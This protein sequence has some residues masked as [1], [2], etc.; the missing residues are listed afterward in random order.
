MVNRLEK[1]FAPL[2]FIQEGKL[3]CYKR[4]CLWVLAGNKVLDKYP[5]FNSAKEFL[6]GAINPFSRLLRLGIRASIALDENRVLLSRGNHIFELDLLSGERSGGYFIGE[7]L[8][9]LA[10]T[11]IEGIRG[12]DDA[13]VFGGYL[14]NMDKEPVHI[15][16]RKSVDQWEVVYTFERGVI[17]HV[18]AI[19]AD[20]YRDCLWAFTGDF[21]EAS[22][23]WRITDNF[24]RVERVAWNDQQYRGCVVFPVREGLLYATDA[25]FAK[26]YIYLMNPDSMELKRIAPIDG[27]CIYGC[28]CGDQFVFSSTVEPDGRDSSLFKLFTSRKRVAGITDMYVHLYCGNMEKGFREIYKERKDLWPYAF[29]FGVF[30]F[31]SG[32]NDANTL[33]FQPIATY[34]NDLSLLALDLSGM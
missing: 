26:N 8:R 25:P 21:D 22:A 17:N 34:K 24:K 20:P 2:C 19:V 28:Q 9:P 14:M 27:S 32:R 12:F 5:I 4:G 3:I 6:I 31:P 13:V 18:H 23:I 15:Y 11:K 30:R 1:G 16:K 7:G 29:Q 10:F 33:Y